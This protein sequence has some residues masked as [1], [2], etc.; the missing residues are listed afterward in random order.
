MM[1]ETSHEEAARLSLASN[2]ASRVKAE[3]TDSLV[4]NTGAQ[5]FLLRGGLGDTE[6]L[7]SGY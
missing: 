5:V 3:L 6:T 7:K 2:E 1:E 4:K